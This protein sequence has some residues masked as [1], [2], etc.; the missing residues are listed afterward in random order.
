MNLWPFCKLTRCEGEIVVNYLIWNYTKVRNYLARDYHIVWNYLTCEITDRS[1]EQASDK[2]NA[3]SRCLAIKL[4]KSVTMLV[5]A[6]DWP[7]HQQVWGGYQIMLFNGTC[8]LLYICVPSSTFHYFLRYGGDDLGASNTTIN[9]SRQ[10]D[11][12]GIKDWVG[13]MQTISIKHGGLLG[14][15]K[16]FDKIKSEHVTSSTPRLILKPK[17]IESWKAILVT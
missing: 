5:G 6:G 7:H 2:T 16:V 3:T 4:L 11:G 12:R 9:G 1:S 14:P 15:P 17:F 10:W 8:H 13:K